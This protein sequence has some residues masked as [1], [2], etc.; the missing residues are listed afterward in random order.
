MEF[1]SKVGADGNGLVFR[2]ANENSGRWQTDA[3]RDFMRYY[4]SQVVR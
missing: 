1:F 4:L 2:R 3:I